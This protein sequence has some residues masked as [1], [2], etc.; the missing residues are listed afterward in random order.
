MYIRIAELW[1]G[2]GMVR[3]GHLD[4]SFSPDG[5]GTSP[6]LKLLHAFTQGPNLLCLITDSFSPT[7]LATVLSPPFPFDDAT[8]PSLDILPSLST[9][10]ALLLP[11]LPV[12][13]TT[14]FFPCG[15]GV[16]VVVAT[17]CGRTGV[18]WSRLNCV[19]RAIMLGPG[20]ADLFRERLEALA[21]RA[22][23]SGGGWEMLRTRRM[24]RSGSVEPVRVRAIVADGG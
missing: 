21:T 24:S 23:V 14:L 10:P 12:L 5:L 20:D 13:F 15:C 6:K 9:D 2:N 7:P 19:L 4:A 16:G 11:V 3:N 8:D 18:G 22:P 1:M 17:C